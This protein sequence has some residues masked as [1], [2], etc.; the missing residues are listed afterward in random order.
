MGVRT[1]RAFVRAF[2]REA[3]REVGEREAGRER[4]EE[5]SWEREREKRAG[6]AVCGLARPLPA[7]FLARLEAPRKPPQAAL[8]RN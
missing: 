3:G 7:S 1:V 4:L 6:G 5:R 2:V 8:R